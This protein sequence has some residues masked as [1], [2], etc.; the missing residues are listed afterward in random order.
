MYGFS[1]RRSGGTLFSSQKEDSPRMS[2]TLMTTKIRRPVAWQA[3]KGVFASRVDPLGPAARIQSP[4]FGEEGRAIAAHP[5]SFMRQRN[6]V[7][8]LVHPGYE[9]TLA[10]AEDR[11]SG[12]GQDRCFSL[13]TI[14]PRNARRTR[15]GRRNQARIWGHT[16]SNVLRIALTVEPQTTYGVGSMSLLDKMQEPDESYCENRE[17][18][19][20]RGKG[21]RRIA[22]ADCADDA[23]SFLCAL[24]VL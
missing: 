22:T 9:G 20:G 18:S 2:W 1:G 7:T 15:R 14:A 11:V 19:L 23:D 24:C 17:G 13:K 21:E 10:S 4:V 3:L 5:W 16:F 6:P 12:T 8:C